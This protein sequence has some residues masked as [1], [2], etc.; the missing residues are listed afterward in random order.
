MMTEITGVDRWMTPE[1]QRRVV[2]MH[3]EVTFR[4]LDGGGLR[5]EI[6]V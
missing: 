3:P 1:R 4:T 6:V 2:E 5:T